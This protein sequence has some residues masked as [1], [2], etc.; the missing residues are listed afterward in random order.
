MKE[1]RKAVFSD[2]VGSCWLFELILDCFFLR[3][4]REMLNKS[5][6]LIGESGSRYLEWIIVKPILVDLILSPFK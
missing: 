4:Y 5:L 6:E 1:T 3:I 2:P